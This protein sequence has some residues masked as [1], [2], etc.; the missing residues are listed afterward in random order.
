MGLLSVRSVD[1][2]PSKLTPLTMYILPGSKANMMRVVN[3]NESG[4]VSYDDDTVSTAELLTLLAVKVDKITGM[5]LSQA[6][7]TTADSA[8]LAGIAANAT[9]NQTDAYLLNRQNHTGFQAIETVTGLN[10]ALNS[11]TAFTNGRYVSTPAE[12]TAA[13]NDLP[14]QQQV[15]NSWLKISNAPTM[16]FPASEPETKA[17][18]FD[19]VNQRIYN[20]T[21]SATFIGAISDRKFDNY[22]L[23]VTIY[24]TNNDDDTIGLILGFYQDP[25]G[26]QYTLS[27]VRSPGGNPN[28]YQLYYNFNQGTPGGSAIIKNG[29]PTVTWGNGASGSLTMAQAGYVSTQPGWGNMGAKWGTDGSTRLWVKREG[30]IITTW[31]SQWQTPTVKDEGTMLTIDLTTDDRLIKFVGSSEYGFC[32]LSQANSYWNVNSFVNPK[33]AIFDLST[34]KV[35][36]HTATGWI[37]STT[38]SFADLAPNQFLVD[39]KNKKIYY[40]TED[41]SIL[42][43]NTTVI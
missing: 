42:L 30:N 1:T 26:R 37:E 43:I 14:D 10:S 27:V 7:Y 12:L 21:N 33:D 32:S 35:W 25:T 15:F 39:S 28:L 4:T 23:D 34:K 17:W 5:G 29:N 36:T 38:I 13:K 8:K 18:G 31:T 19:T 40:I 11:K 16:L 41:R 9:K 22:E 6:N 2:L 3:V 20:T 24:S